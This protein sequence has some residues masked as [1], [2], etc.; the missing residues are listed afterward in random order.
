MA[1]PQL[2]VLCSGLALALIFSVLLV[3]WS[4]PAKSETAVFVVTE[5]ASPCFHCDSFLLPLTD[6]QQIAAARTLVA[7]GPGGGV[8][9]IPV[10]TIAA[11]SDGLNRDMLAAGEPLWNWHVTGFSGF[12]EFTIELCDGWPGFVEPDPAG[13]IAN[14]GGQFCPWSYSVTAEVLPAAEVPSLSI[15]N[16]SGLGLLLL[17]LYLF[18]L[19][20]KIPVPQRMV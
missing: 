8:G 13:F 7:N 14:T 1:M 11:G 17:G 20:K 2:R 10:V 9:T 3:V 4:Q 19:K 18:A 16:R 5:L 15:W 12:A 6:P